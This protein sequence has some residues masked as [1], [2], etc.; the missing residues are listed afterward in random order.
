LLEDGGGVAARVLREF[1]VDLEETR[2]EIIKELTP[3]F[4]P[5]DSEPEKQD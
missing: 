5:D 1:N 4:P 2:K 3:D